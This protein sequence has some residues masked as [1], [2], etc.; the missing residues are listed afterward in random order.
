MELAVVVLSLAVGYVIGQI[1]IIVLIK[2]G[3]MD[4][5]LDWLSDSIW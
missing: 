3:W 4:K 1:L 2:L 5:I